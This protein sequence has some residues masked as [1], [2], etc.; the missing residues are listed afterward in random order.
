MMKHHKKQRF[1][2]CWDFVRGSFF[3]NTIVLLVGNRAFPMFP[4]NHFVWGS[5]LGKVIYLIPSDT[6]GTNFEVFCDGMTFPRIP[7]SCKSSLRLFPVTRFRET[8]RKNKRFW[9]AVQKGDPEKGRPYIYIVFQHMRE[10]RIRQRVGRIYIWRASD[11]TDCLIQSYTI[12]G[13]CV[14]PYTSGTYAQA[15]TKSINLQFQARE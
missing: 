9:G 11:S 12:R 15:Y 2:V 8:W 4:G 14:G 1:C 6:R 3:G 7:K 5:C 10:R 13:K